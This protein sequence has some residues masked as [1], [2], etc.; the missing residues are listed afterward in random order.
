MVKE[1]LERIYSFF[2]LQETFPP[3]LLWWQ[4]IILV[5]AYLFGASALLYVLDQFCLLNLH[6]R[7]SICGT[8][9]A[10]SIVL[11]IL[12]IDRLIRHKLIDHRARLVDH[13]DVEALF[14]EAKTVEARLTF[15]EGKP[16]KPDDYKKKEEE[17]RKEVERLEKLGHE[18][19]TEYQVLSLSQM[20]IDFL[21]IDD[22]KARARS[23][24]TDLEE[25]VV[26]SAY[27]IDQRLLYHWE[28]RIN[29]A[30]DKIDEIK[31]KDIKDLELDDIAEK[32][33]A[34]LRTLLEDVAS[35][36]ESWAKG[37]IIVR[38]LT[39]LGVLTIP[40]LLAMGLLPL[41]HPD[42]NKILGIPNWGLFGISG[43]ITGVL[44]SLRQ[45]ILVEVGNTEG[46]KELRHAILGTGLGLVAGILLYSMIAGGILSGALFP[47]ITSEP[48]KPDELNSN[49][50]R[51]IFWGIAS[52]FSFEWVFDRVR[53]TTAGER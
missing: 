24:L 36:E 3:K 37:S 38:A 10:L 16:L 44:L 31:N 18:G 9:I 42:G 7:N 22:L 46:K 17:L 33:R 47:K 5:T 40:I 1:I 43:A 25:Y 45:S 8:Y 27:P 2:K 35:Y 53:N 15:P 20:L 52:G 21:K 26:D 32:L 50:A 6:I 49:L 19:W 41:L 29:E 23:T 11:T 12:I 39:V 48:L 51:S 13:S 28:D 30:I 34:E 14:V 4:W